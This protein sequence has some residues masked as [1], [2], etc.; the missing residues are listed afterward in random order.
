M[1]TKKDRIILPVVSFILQLFTMSTFS[2]PVT[3][4]TFVW[5]VGLDLMKEEWKCVLIEGGGQCVM[6][7]GV[8]M[9]QKLYADSLDTLHGVSNNLCK[10]DPI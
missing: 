1:Y 6:T 2:G 9:M 5:L 7:T 10:L 3:L 8:A 4:E